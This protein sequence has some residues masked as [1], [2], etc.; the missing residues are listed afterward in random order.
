MGVVV[1]TADRLRVVLTAPFVLGRMTLA[2]LA[3]GVPIVRDAVDV[4]TIRLLRRRMRA[5]GHPGC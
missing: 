5:Y 3:S 4:L 2:V 1:T